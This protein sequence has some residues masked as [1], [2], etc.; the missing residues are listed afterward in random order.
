MQL[1]DQLLQSVLHIANEAGKILESF[2]LKSESIEIHTKSDNTPVTEVDLAIS[3]FLIQK[4]ATL[5]PD[6]PILSEE[7]CNIPLSERQSWETY[8]LIDPLDGTQRFIERTGQFSILIAL[9]HQNRPILG[10]I[11]APILQKTYYAMQGFGAYKLEDNHHQRLTARHIDTTQ[12]LKI[13][14]GSENHKQ[15]VRCILPEN[16]PCEFLVYGSSG[17]KGGLVADG[18]ADCYV[19]LGDTGEWDTAA[20]EILLSE[21]NGN[22]FEP[23]FLPLTYNQR[24]TFI[25][26]HFVMTAD[27]EVNWQKIFCFN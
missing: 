1:T 5:T 4:L 19:R 15:K 3:Q 9:I 6:I 21:L 16:F 10:I 18:T 11:H 26:P 7:N 14:V 12:P 22:I 20:A 8:W 17:L 27:R 25:N 13:A 2:Y 24:E 23:H